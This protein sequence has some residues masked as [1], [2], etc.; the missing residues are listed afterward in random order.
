MRK[1]PKVNIKTTKS[2]VRYQIIASN[3]EP[4]CTS[5]PYPTVTHAK[6]GAMALIRACDDLWYSDHKAIFVMA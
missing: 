2:G 5:E 1:Q 4:L 3:G 6:R